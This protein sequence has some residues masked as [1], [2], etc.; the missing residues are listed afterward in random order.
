MANNDWELSAPEDHQPQSATGIPFY[1]DPSAAPGPSVADGANGMSFTQDFQNARGLSPEA[2][3]LLGGKYS[4]LETAGQLGSDVLAGIG[5]G[6]NALYR[7][8]DSISGSARLGTQLGDILDSAP[9][10]EGANLHL[11]IADSIGYLKG[12][13]TGAGE[14]APLAT[15]LGEH[16]AEFQK[17]LRDGDIVTAEAA[18]RDAGQTVDATTRDQLKTARDY[19]ANG[20]TA[21]T[22]WEH[23]A[24]EPLSPQEEAQ[25]AANDKYE[26]AKAAGA[27]THEAFNDLL[28]THGQEPIPA[29]VPQVPVE[30]ENPNPIARQGLPTVQNQQAALEDAFGKPEAP[31]RREQIQTATQALQESAEPGKT[32]VVQPFPEDEPDYH[33]FLYTAN[34]G[35]QVSGYYTYDAQ[36]GKVE[37]LSVGENGLKNQ[38]GPAGIRSILRGIQE[39]HPDLTGVEGYRISGARKVAGQVAEDV[40]VSIRP[41]AGEYTVTSGNKT[42]R[43]NDINAARREALRLAHN[44]GEFNE[45]FDSIRGYTGGDA[46][47][48]P[49]K[50]SHSLEE[51]GVREP[52]VGSDNGGTGEQPPADSGTPDTK[53]VDPDEV[54]SRITEAL[55]NAGKD[56]REQEAL[57]TEARKAKLAKVRAAAA[58]SDGEEGFHSELAGLKGELPKVEGANIREQFSQEEIDSLF[59]KVKEHG[60][61]TYEGIRART[62]LAKLLDG[63][64]PTNS[65]IA[66]LAKVFPPEFI[67]TLLKESGHIGGQG[68]LF[69]GADVTASGPIKELLPEKKPI[70]PDKYVF[71]KNQGDFFPETR[72]P[73]E[74]NPISVP[75]GQGE[76]FSG[77]DTT[78]SGPI[79]ELLPEPKAIDPDKFVVPKGQMDLFAPKAEVKP[80]LKGQGELFSGADTHATGPD[81]A[82]LAP[83]PKPVDP[84]KYTFDKNQ[85]DFF[86]ETRE[87]GKLKPIVDDTPKPKP[88]EKAG[89]LGGI[90]ALSRSLMASV[91]LSAPFTQGAFLVGRKEFWKSFMPMFK[92]AWSEEGF[93]GVTKSIED[94]PTYPLMEK[95]G[96]HI[97]DIHDGLTAGE[98]AF[99][100]AHL[101]EK[102]PFAGRLVRGS[103]RAYTAFLNKLRADTFNT[104][105]GKFSDAGIDLGHPDNAKELK[106]LAGFVNNATGRGELGRFAP[107]GNVLG[108]A[109]FSPRLMASRVNL[110]NPAYYVKLDPIVRKEAI[111]SLLSM[112]GAGLAVAGLSKL[113]GNPVEM[114]PRSSDF[115]QIQVGNTR[116]SLTGGFGPYIVLGARLAT[117]SADQ[118]LRQTGSDKRVAS[119]KNA[120][121]SFSNYN[122]GKYGKPTAE[123]AIH[124]FV[125][126]KFSPALS[127]FYD[128]FK[129]KDHD[130]QPFSITKEAIQHFIPLFLQNVYDVINDRNLKELPL[131]IPAL[132]GVQTQTYQPKPT[133]VK[134]NGYTLS[135]PSTS[136]PAPVSGGWDLSPASTTPVSSAPASGG[137]ALSKAN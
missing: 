112:G 83:E 63:D 10:V 102:I 80:E 36:T 86:P 27:P 66:S 137:W 74:L 34:D 20:G 60:L 95:G 84:D 15:S 70:D 120:D 24:P 16:N 67:K 87:P 9:G 77:A 113:A 32:S 19:Y 2:T 132:F 61:S 97:G 8:L 50:I 62:S 51:G 136:G 73:G 116:Q 105:A 52:P 40:G 33:R 37:N 110:L 107:A 11:P 124:D 130:F 22:V 111:K 59:N 109:L 58:T 135:G 108:T 42:I 134:E 46:S 57:Y 72:K 29:E 91:D 38:V 18:L 49:V 64:V 25:A 99:I 65:E 103:E 30:P 121:G 100:G 93:N 131:L 4:P 98:E 44:A 56:R 14:A 68:E 35:K 7:G 129:G 41:N 128:W 88:P 31:T 133:K 118:V 12:A 13:V 76:L 45:H 5:A 101:A 53:K 69:R 94:L 1:G 39:E 82:P 96:I 81:K 90:A 119:K 92:A 26:A 117:A 115:M 43:V 79:R 17:A 104:I 6:S 125:T 123:D 23:R 48:G 54:A 71:N 114:D 55:K 122:D 28:A 127:F 3:A 126:N 85:G 75:K 21:D 78:S 89:I 47:F 106:D